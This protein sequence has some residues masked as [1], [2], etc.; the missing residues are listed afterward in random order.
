MAPFDAFSRAF[1]LLPVGQ[2]AG[3]PLRNPFLMATPGYAELAERFAG[4]SFDEG[5]YRIFDAGGGAKATQLARAVY[6]GGA[7][8]LYPFAMDWLGR[9]FALDAERV[10]DGEPQIMLLEIG[11]GDALEVPYGLVAFHDDHLT[12]DPEPALAVAGWGEWSALHPE[13]L[14]LPAEKCVGYE[15]PLFLGGQDTPDNME[16][17]DWEV[18]W[19]VVG[20][21]KL[22]TDG[23]AEGTPIR[24]IGAG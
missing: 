11:T 7:Q 5:L 3:A 20:R 8:R 16:V 19:T 21:L 18:Y 9:M 10:V 4:C 24:D 22:R 12:E 17:S 23:L 1:S 14:P 13:T 6:P 2:T 15:L